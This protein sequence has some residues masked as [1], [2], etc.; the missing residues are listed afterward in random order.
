M[1]DIP[2][3]RFEGVLRDTSRAVLVAFYDPGVPRC[4]QL[5]PVNNIY[6][7]FLFSSLFI[8]QPFLQIKKKVYDKLGRIFKNDNI[9]FV[10]LNIANSDAKE[11]RNRFKLSSYP[12]AFLFPVDRKGSQLEDAIEYKKDF[13]EDSMLAFLNLNLGT[14]RDE[15]GRS[16]DEG[17][18]PDFDELVGKLVS[19]DQASIAHLILETTKAEERAKT[20]KIYMK[21]AAKFVQDGKDFPQKEFDR[22][23]NMVNSPEITKEKRNEFQLRLNILRSFL[24]Y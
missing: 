11:L 14:N 1:I 21:Y 19:G 12:A 6:F 24:I 3:R 17:K 4:I 2:V 23:R 15:E 9:L 10:R 7:L 8:Y 16:L 20:A 5:A 13:E 18:L 22:I